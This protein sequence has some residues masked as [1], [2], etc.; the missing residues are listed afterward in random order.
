MVFSMGQ[1][2][3]ILANQEQGILLSTIN[4][5]LFLKEL[6]ILDLERIINQNLWQ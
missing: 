3:L 1:V 2:S 5:K 6:L 4:S